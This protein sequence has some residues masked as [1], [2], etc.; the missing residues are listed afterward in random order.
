[1]L[2]TPV[3]P[4][5]AQGA[6]Q[7]VEDAAVLAR[8]L[9]QF[10]EP[11][12]AIARYETIRKPRTDKIQNGSWDNASV[13]HLE[14][15]PQQKARDEFYSAIVEQGVHPLAAFDE[16]HGYDVLAEAI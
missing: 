13:F 10:S 4:F 8:C 15:G 9:D 14:D 6:C 3:L 1:M 11:E 2:R 7:A 5:M 12:A 16:L